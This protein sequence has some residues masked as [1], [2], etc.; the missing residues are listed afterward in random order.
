MPLQILQSVCTKPRI[1]LTYGS[2][3]G[4]VYDLNCFFFLLS[5]LYLIHLAEGYMFNNNNKT[6]EAFQRHVFPFFL[7]VLLSFSLVYLS[8]LLFDMYFS[9]A[10]RISDLVFSLYS[11]FFTLS[12]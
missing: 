11:A 8:R 2:Y 6:I 7:I 9:K 10:T 12:I 1:Y 5:K 4:T 3:L